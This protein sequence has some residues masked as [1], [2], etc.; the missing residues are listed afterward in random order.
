[1]A[2]ERFQNLRGGNARFTNPFIVRNCQDADRQS[3]RA[4]GHG[5][6]WHSRNV[7]TYE[8]TCH[9]LMSEDFVCTNV[10]REQAIGVSLDHLQ[11][12]CLEGQPHILSR[13]R[14]FIDQEVYTTTEC[15]KVQQR[16]AWPCRLCV[17]LHTTDS[18]KTSSRL[19]SS[20]PHSEAIPPP[21]QVF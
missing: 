11:I 20:V 15:Q 18:P 7:L 12:C 8:L 10:A 6:L 14:A 4:Q 1:M 16:C 21:I 3:P 17:Q 2:G 19:L 9:Q 13:I 5:Q